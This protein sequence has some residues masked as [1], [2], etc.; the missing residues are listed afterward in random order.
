MNSSFLPEA[1]EQGLIRRILIMTAVEAEQAAILRGWNVN[2]ESI[3]VEVKLAGVGPAAAA[4]NTAIALASGDY[5]LVIS[6]GIAGG[7]AGTAEIGSV[8]VATTIEQADLG[9]ET[10]E[11]FASVDEL[12]F[13]SSRLPAHAAL[14]TR[15]SEALAAAG[16]PVHTGPVL[17]VSAATGTALTAAARAGRSPGAVA[18]AMEGFG[19]AVAADK[20]GLP[21][22]EIRAISNVVG[23]RDKAAWRIGDALR[24]LETAITHL[25]EVLT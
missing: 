20:F 11:G 14:S 3:Q 17:T 18:E 9:A 1:P 25:Q 10:G 7:F 13:G 5:D 16:I 15:L 4:A 22:M 8:V 6:A 2:H 12:G 21:I 24:A 19:V 23:P